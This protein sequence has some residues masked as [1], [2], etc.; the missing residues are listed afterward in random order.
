V[1]FGCENHMYANKVGKR[2]GDWIPVFTGMTKG[3]GVLLFPLINAI[4]WHTPNSGENA[5][6]TG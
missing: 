4:L 2:G 3:R 1:G 5:Y 6:E